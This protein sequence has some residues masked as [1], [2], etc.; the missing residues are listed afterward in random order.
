MP[1]NRHSCY[2]HATKRRQSS[3][4]KDCAIIALL[5]GSTNPIIT[6]IAFW[7]TFHSPHAP[8]RCGGDRHNTQHNTN[9]TC[10]G[11]FALCRGVA[12]RLGLQHGQLAGTS[13]A[14]ATRGRRH[15]CAQRV[16]TR[17]P[18]AQ[19]NHQQELQRWVPSAH[20]ARSHA[21]MRRAR[22]HAPK[23]NVAVHERSPHSSPDTRRAPS[24]RLFTSAPY[25]LGAAAFRGVV[26]CGGG[27]RRRRGIGPPAVA[28]VA[29]AVASGA[30]KSL[31]SRQ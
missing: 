25:L 14:S 9:H 19:H 1:R 21:Q 2:T 22:A 31:A 24:W 8:G 26:G 5:P 27:G 29:R 20:R 16:E 6:Q 30:G 28:T 18:P 4:I 12:R 10:R 13:A 17:I 11:A 15:P 3:A 23:R 7:R